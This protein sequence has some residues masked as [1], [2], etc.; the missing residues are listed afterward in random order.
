[1]LSRRLLWRLRISQLML[2]AT[3]AALVV[4]AAV[5]GRT[6]ASPRAAL[7]ALFAV[8]V[9]SAALTISYA[10]GNVRREA[11]ALRQLQDAVDRLAD[12]DINARVYLDNRDD[13][14]RLG[15]GF[16]RMSGMLADRVLRL[17]RDREQLRAVL[18]GMVEGVVALDAGQHVLF[19]NEQALRLLD[20]PAGETISRRFWEVV[21]QRPL[22]DLIDRALAQ[23]EP[24]RAELDWTGGP[25][26]SLTVHAA[27]LSA[28]SGGAVLVLQ[29][30]T[31]LR[32]LERLRQDFAA[33]VSHELKTPLAV[34][35]ACVE[36]LLDG[37]ADDAEAR[38]RFLTQIDDQTSRLHAL[39]LD[40]LNLAR[41]ESGAELFEFG[42]VPVAK[43]VEAC[44]ERHR[45]RAEARQQTL[46]VS[47][48]PDDL[49]VWADE[50]AVEQ[51]LDNLLD[52]AVKYTP[53]GGRVTVTWLAVEAQV[54]LEVADTGVGIPEADLARV[55]ERFYRVDKARSRAV[56]GTGLGLAIVKHLVQAMNGSVRAA[57]RVGHGTTFIVRLP[58]AEAKATG[59]AG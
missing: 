47:G 43:A 58:R 54:A 35:R 37:A 5:E 38:D 16:N 42:R 28:G 19:A 33:N 22:L 24:V 40:L 59:V 20:L 27:R 29:D 44:V 52:N 23:T 26:R 12:G 55:F 4:L 51:I 11:G 30:T 57:S 15:D 10:I 36:T 9:I 3:A 25:G 14:G 46:S 32:R 2:A 6:E 48:G 50:E 1:M 13:V 34:I 18:R 31:E 56:G 7:A 21:R 8:V 17:E 39:I 45:A 53:E 41:I 49:A